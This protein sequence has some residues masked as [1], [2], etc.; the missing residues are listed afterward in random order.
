MPEDLHYGPRLSDDEYERRIIDFHRGLRPMPTKEQDMAVR[1]LELDLAID[2]RLG[3]DFPQERRA[4]LWA[5]QQ[6]VEKRRLWLALKYLLRR[7]FP[8]KLA[9]QVQHLAGYMVDEYAKVL[10]EAELE[11]FF[12]LKE[13]QRPVLPIDPDQL[14]K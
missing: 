2:H 9:Q 3:R 8:N 12:S 4:A 5:V 13:G 1:R 6:R 11:S 7:I 14:K 10:N